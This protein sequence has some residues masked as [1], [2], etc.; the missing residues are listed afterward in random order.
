MSEKQKKQKTSDPLKG[1]TAVVRSVGHG[2]KTAMVTMVVQKAGGRPKFS[3]TRHLRRRTDGDYADREGRTY[4]VDIDRGK[5]VVVK[6]DNTLLVCE[7]PPP[8]TKKEKVVAVA[9]E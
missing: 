2:G 8:K 7:L 1:S 5:K 6:V 9:E 3:V 4:L